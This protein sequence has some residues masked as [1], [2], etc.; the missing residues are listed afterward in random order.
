MGTPA[1]HERVMDDTGESLRGSPPLPKK[2]PRFLVF[3]VKKIRDRPAVRRKNL[4]SPS[5]SPRREDAPDRPG[6]A[7]PAGRTGPDLRSA[8]HTPPDGASVLTRR[9]Q[10]D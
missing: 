7:I 3:R 9:T 5:L 6:A 10:C 1:T 8:W 4:T 2:P